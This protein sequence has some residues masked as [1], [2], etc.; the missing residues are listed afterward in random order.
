MNLPGFVWVILGP[1]IFFAYPLRSLNEILDPS[2]ATAARP[3]KLGLR[4]RTP[5]GCRQFASALRDASLGHDRCPNISPAPG[6]GCRA[7]PGTCGIWGEALRNYG[8]ADPMR[9]FPSCDRVRGL[10]ISD[11]PSQESFTCSKG[12]FLKC[13]EDDRASL[14]IRWSTGAL[15]L[16]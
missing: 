16:C 15:L 4:P 12:E 2:K 10:N 13:T 9:P 14:I 1:C 7:A 3:R 6:C 8:G 11:C 5:A